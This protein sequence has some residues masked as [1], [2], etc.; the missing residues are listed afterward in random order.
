MLFIEWWLVK[1]AFI[2]LL[3]V[4]I[5]AV[6]FWHVRKKTWPIRVP[7]QLVCA[8]VGLS[9]VLGWLFILA[10]G[11]PDVYSTPVYS[12]NGAMAVRIDDF[13][14]GGLG[15]AYDNVELFTAHGLDSKIVFSGDWKSVERANLHWKSNSELEI[16]HAGNGRCTSTTHVTVHCIG[17]TTDSR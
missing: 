11:S 17:Q 13:N 15:G 5:P 4:A 3:V 9:G 10:L 2:G 14:A 1:R 6:G 7:V 8:L 16:L 12:P